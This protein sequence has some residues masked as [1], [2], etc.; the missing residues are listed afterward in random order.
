MPR[1][2]PPADAFTSSGRPICAASTPSACSGT[3]RRSAPGT[4][5]TPAAVINSR[6]ASFEPIASIADGGGPT[7]TTPAARHARANAAFSERNPY[8]GCTASAPAR[9]AAVTTAS[10]RR[11]D[12]AGVA[13][14]SATALSASRTNIASASGSLY[15]ATVSIPI[16]RQVRMMRHAISPRFAMRSLRMVTCAPTSGTH[17]S[18][19]GLGSR[20]S[21]MPTTRCRAPLAC[22]AGR[23]L[24]RR[25][26]GRS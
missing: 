10:M 6:A 24:R 22:R 19:V 25:G 1:P 18:R 11:Y 13:P 7:H 2:P 16:A 9:R 17:R 5:A 20:S 15:T 26:C 12:V 23:S 4:T 21:D 8:P 14:P 3:S